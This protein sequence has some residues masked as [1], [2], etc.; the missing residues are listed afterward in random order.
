M[1]GISG[2]RGLR[3]EAGGLLQPPGELSLA[4]GRVKRGCRGGVSG[5]SAGVPGKALLWEGPEEA[6]EVPGRHR[7][8]RGCRRPR[9]APGPGASRAADSLHS[10]KE[11]PVLAPVGVSAQGSHNRTGRRHT[12]GSRSSRSPLHRA[13]PHKEHSL[14]LPGL[15][16]PLCR[17]H[18]GPWAF[19]PAQ[20]RA[21]GPLLKPSPCMLRL[22]GVPAE[23]RPGRAEQSP[24][25]R[26]PRRRP[27]RGQGWGPGFP[28]LA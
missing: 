18:Q 19:P 9:V 15:A 16:C 24:W 4:A 7:P 13:G 2:E 21:T 3:P 14:L 20:L 11:G 12:T 8:D 25:C 1:K 17:P 23:G 6:W 28:V 22:P 27:W 10:C 5:V 26:A